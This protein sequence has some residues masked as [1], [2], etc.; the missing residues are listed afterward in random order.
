VVEGGGTSAD[1]FLKLKEDTYRRLMLNTDDAVKAFGRRIL[2]NKQDVKFEKLSKDQRKGIFDLID[3]RIKLGNRNFMNKHNDLDVG[4]DPE[5]FASGGRASFAGGGAAWKF[6]M[7]FF[8][9]A[10]IK[11]SNEIRQGLG[12]WKGLDWKQKM[13]QHDNFTKIIDDII[14]TGKYNK[15]ADE[16]IG[17]DVKKAFEAAEAKVKK[18]DLS[19]YT[20]KDLNALVAEDKKILAEA[21]KLSEAGTNYGRVSEIEARRKEIKEILEAAQDIPPS[22]YDNFKADLALKKQVSG[23]DQEI[24]KGVEDVMKD[25]SEAGLAKSIE[26]DNL[27]LEFPGISDEMIGNILT[28]TNPQRIAEVKQTMREALK[29]GEKGMSP[30]EIINVFKGTSRTKQAAGG[31]A[32]QLHL[33]EGGRTGFKKGS[34]RERLQKDYKSYARLSDF[35]K[36]APPNFWLFPEKYG[37]TRDDAMTYLKERFMYGDLDADRKDNASGGR[38]SYT[39]G[40]LAHVLGV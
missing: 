20:D 8:E 32:G 11:T 12:K 22:G 7:K 14:K 40:G 2:E 34:M 15:K 27:K 18:V 39:K 3:D 13:V 9:P 35:L 5:D 37:M 21:N 1:D 28:D 10:A 38:V 6:F 17:F 16:Y 30:D 19:K 24:K 23:I 29:M 26:I 25:T 36:T 33:N 31:I 4:F